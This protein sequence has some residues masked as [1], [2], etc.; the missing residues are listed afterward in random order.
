MAP[1]GGPRKSLY[2]SQKW[3]FP[4]FPFRGSVGG[5]RVRN[6]KGIQRFPQVTPSRGVSQNS[7]RGPPSRG[8]AFSF[9]YALPPPP[10]TVALLRTE[11]RAL[12]VKPIAVPRV[13]CLHHRG[14]CHSGK[15]KA[16]KLK[17]NAR[18]TGRVPLGH[19][20]GQTGRCPRHF[21][22]IAIEKRTEKGVFAGTPAGCPRDTLPSRGFSEILCDFFLCAFSAP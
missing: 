2:G 22:L 1:R 17:K 13:R 19:Q 6:S 11:V 5:Q 12:T 14:A 9:R 4:D 3:Y 21:L 15:R 7:F 20:A 10:V 16:H 8:I 18:D